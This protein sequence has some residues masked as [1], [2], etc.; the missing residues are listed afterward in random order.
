VLPSETGF[1]RCPFPVLFSVLS[2]CH[3][4]VSFFSALISKRGVLGYGML[5]A[6]VLLL[7]YR[8]CNWNR[9]KIGGMTAG[10]HIAQ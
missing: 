3:A 6:G 9:F 7:P 2:V 10:Y 5:L 4:S 8:R 1:L